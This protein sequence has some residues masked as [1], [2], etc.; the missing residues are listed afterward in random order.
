MKVLVTGGAGYIGSLLVP[1]LLHMGHKVRVLDN[2]MYGQTSLLPFFIEE[3]FEFMKGDIRDF[4]VVKKAVDGVDIV[5]HLAAIVGA[6]ACRRDPKLAEDINHNGT[7]NIDKA[8]D[9]SQKLI[10][11]STGSVYGALKDICTEESPSNPL[12]TYGITKL[13][14]ENQVM[15]SGN[16]I[17][18]RFATAFGLSSRMRLDLLPNDFTFQ[19]VKNGSLFLFEKHFR[20]TFIHVRDMVRSYLFAIKNFDRLKDKIYNVGSEKLNCTKEEIALAI[21]EK[22]DYTL[23]FID[24]GSD[25][26]KRDYEVSY[27]K[28]RNKGFETKISLKQGIEELI[29][30]YQMLSLKSPYSNV[31][32]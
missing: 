23:I 10:Y 30:G 7:V 25:P 31:E 22:I 24:K 16:A 19:A 3:N 32:E 13:H 17:V 1:E 8:R 11:A 29:K 5:I 15:S 20:R 9:K 18:F 21:K 6:P 14:A 26:D 27:Q 12:T 4:E 2:L 28:I